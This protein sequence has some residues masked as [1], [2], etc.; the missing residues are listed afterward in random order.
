VCRGHLDEAGEAADGGGRVGEG[1]GFEDGDGGSC[2]V[3]RI[4]S[5]GTGV[6]GCKSGKIGEGGVR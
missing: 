6:L 5:V 1:M 2:G 4:S 3:G